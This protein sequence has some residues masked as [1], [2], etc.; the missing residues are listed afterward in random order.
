MRSLSWTNSGPIDIIGGTSSRTLARFP[1]LSLSFLTELFVII[2]N[3]A[4]EH[5]PFIQQ[6]EM[7]P[8]TTATEN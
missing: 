8:E 1:Y 5:F 7:G 2:V 3:N 4:L 6:G